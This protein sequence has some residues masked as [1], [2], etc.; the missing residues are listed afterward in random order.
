MFIVVRDKKEEEIC[1]IFS[2]VSVLPDRMLR[3]TLMFKW[4]EANGCNVK[5][6][7]FSYLSDSDAASVSNKSTLGSH[8][9]QTCLIMLSVL[10]SDF[11]H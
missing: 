4:E 5:K 1:R 3:D 9:S 7:V 11:D 2:T 10:L 8:S 6:A